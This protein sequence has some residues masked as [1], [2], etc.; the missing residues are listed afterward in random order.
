MSNLE[1]FERAAKAT[2]CQVLEAAG[3]SL[4]RVGAVGLVLGGTGWVPIGTGAL[5]L[6]AANYVCSDMPEGPATPISGLI[7]GCGQL[8]P[9]GYGQFEYKLPGGDWFGPQDNWIFT[10]AVRINPV[11]PLEPTPP[12]T[13]WQVNCEVYSETDGTTRS[14]FFDTEAEASAV[15]F[16]INPTV[17][18]CAY[19][20]AN[21]LPP[22]PPDAQNTYTYTDNITNCT[23]NLTLQ[24]FVQ[25]IEGGGIEPVYLMEAA[26]QLRESSGGRMGGCN[27]PPVIFAPGGGGGGGNGPVYI[28]VPDGPEPPPGP[29][30]IPWWADAILTALGAV[31]LEKFVDAILEALEAPQLPSTFTLTAPCDKDEE[32]NPAT[33]EW[34]FP[35][36]PYENRVLSHQVALMEIMQQQLDWKTPTCDHAK[37]TLLGS[38][39][40]T[41]WESDS[42]SPASNRPLRKLFRYRSQSTR[43]A[44]QLREYWSAFVWQAGPICVRHTGAWWGNPQVWASTPEEG[45]R[46]IRFAGTEA[47]LDPDQTGEWAVSSSDSP[48]YGMPGT[49]RLEEANG[50]RWVTRRDGPDGVPV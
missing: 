22:L 41:R 46:V 49:M 18:E 37:P 10:Q 20:P 14:L 47:G 48:R 16:R 40:S 31:L 24:G 42:N 44:E 9:G 39:I 3:D 15:R 2:T 25:P 19:D 1:L 27:F 29:D 13:E 12:M 30:G 35:E 4:V 34:E 17:G 11:G 28:P 7:D 33:R 50:L 26:P 8:A 21:P 23:Y 5:S 43:D 32:G 38:W 36:E 45:K 6:L